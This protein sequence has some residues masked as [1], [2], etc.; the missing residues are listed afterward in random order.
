MRRGLWLLILLACCKTTVGIEKV[1]AEAR[2]PL[3]QLIADLRALGRWDVVGYA[4]P[5]ISVRVDAA[6]ISQYNQEQ[7][8]C[9]DALYD[10]V[11]RV[12]TIS[13]QHE[14]TACYQGTTHVKLS[15]LG[16]KAALAHELG[17][18]AGLEHS[19]SGIM[20]PDGGRECIYHIAEC[21]IIALD[22][23]KKAIDRQ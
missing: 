17:H 23:A 16:Q 11:Q 9:A 3:D 14:W 19:T 1:D 6:F 5:G 2:E 7:K 20:S 8:S 22:Q 12:A 21:L 18:A 10:R 15:L 4:K 13:S